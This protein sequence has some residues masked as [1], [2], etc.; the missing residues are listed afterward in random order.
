MKSVGE[1]IRYM[2][3]YSHTMVGGVRGQVN[4]NDFE[5]RTLFNEPGLY[6]QMLVGEV[7][8]GAWDY[9]YRATLYDDRLDVFNPELSFESGRQEMKFPGEGSGTFGSRIE[10]RRYVLYGLSRLFCHGSRERSVVM[11]QLSFEAADGLFDSL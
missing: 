4:L 1:M 2:N 8:T 3:I 6:V 7:E 5:V 10:A 9:G 11:N